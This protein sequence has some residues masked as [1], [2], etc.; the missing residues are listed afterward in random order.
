M[1]TEFNEK[2]R[3]AKLAGLPKVETPKVEEESKQQLDENVVGIGAIN[4]P[5]PTREPNDYELAFEHFLGEVYDSKKEG[6]E[7][8]EISDAEKEKI[9]K[10]VDAV[11]DDLDQISKLAKDAGEDAKDITDLVGEAEL[12]EVDGFGRGSGDGTEGFG[13][14]DDT[15]RDIEEMYKKHG[16]DVV[17]EVLEMY[18]SKM[19]K[20][21]GMEE[22]STTDA[23]FQ[24]TGFAEAKTK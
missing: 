24:K 22:N 19:K 5:F 21:K 9:E 7:E 10:E 18:H 3:W 15:H 16:K 11:R 14:M 13:D 20:N 8:E 2:A 23:K 12:E 6:L 17:D 1:S 4:S